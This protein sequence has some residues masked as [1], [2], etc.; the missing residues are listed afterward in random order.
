VHLDTALAQMGGERVERAELDHVQGP[1]AHHLGCAA[2]PGGGQPVR[3]RRQDAAGQVVGEFAEGQIE[4]AR[5]EPLAGRR[6][7]RPAA[8]PADV[9]HQHLVTG[10]GQPG[11]G[12]VDARG[13]PARHARGDQ[14]P[15]AGA[16]LGGRRRPGSGRETFRHAGRGV[17]AV[18]EHR[19]QDAVDAGDVDDAVHHGDVARADV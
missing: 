9:E 1:Q 17:G 4:Y 14:R 16:E 19:R 18:R 7:Q 6:L 5:E 15:V 8:G 12:G 13:R 2:P 10:F 11:T 3:T